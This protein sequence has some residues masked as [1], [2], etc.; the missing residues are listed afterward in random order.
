MVIPKKVNYNNPAEFSIEALEVYYRIHA[1]ILK[2]ISKAEREKKVIPEDTCKKYYEIMKT[3]QLDPIFNGSGCKP[4]AGRF[5][6]KRKIANADDGNAAK[7]TR[8]DET[9]TT[10]MRDMVEVMD[11]MID[12]IEFI[13]DVTKFS[14]ENL[15]RLSELQLDTIDRIIKVFPNVEFSPTI[16]ELL[17]HRCQCIGK[18]QLLIRTTREVENKFD[19]SSSNS[20]IWSWVLERC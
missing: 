14:T 17:W 1:S 9:S 5:F 13:N 15:A 3:T 8:A 19:V 20:A 2:N 7:M 16:H 6:N 11:G 4:K 10:I 12:E 18:C